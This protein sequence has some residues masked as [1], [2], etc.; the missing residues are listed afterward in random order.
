MLIKRP[1]DIKSSEIT[2]ESTY[3]NRRSFIQKAFIFAGTTA[4]T[5]ILYKMINPR[6]PVVYEGEKLAG[7]RPASAEIIP[8]I[9]E[10]QTSLLDITNYNN[11][12]EFSTD[13][14]EVAEFAQGFVSKPW[15]VSIE[16]LVNKP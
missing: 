7:V 1:G 10:K 4:A 8:V 3:V 11:F 9:N 16:G 12:Y 6:P 2:D 14:R 15:T 13:K 5:G